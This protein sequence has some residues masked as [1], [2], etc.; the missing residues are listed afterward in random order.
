MP[1]H[2]KYV[3]T[4]ERIAAPCECSHSR[5]TRHDTGRAGDQTTQGDTWEVTLCVSSVILSGRS[6]DRAFHLL[7]DLASTFFISYPKK[8]VFVFLSLLK[9]QKK[10]KLT[11]NKIKEHLVFCNFLL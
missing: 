7:S 5:E 3:P 8:G 1:T 9:K 11:N 4:H 2:A 10:K 6:V